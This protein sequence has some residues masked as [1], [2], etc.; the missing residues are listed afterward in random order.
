[1]KLAKRE[2]K[3]IGLLE[4]R[5]EISVSELSGLLG[6]SEST[7]RKQLAVM[8]ENGYLIRTY[9]GVMSVNRVPDETFESK[10]HKN[11]AEK[12]RIAEQARK[13][14]P[15]GSSVALGSGTTVYALSTLLDDLG[16]GVFYSNSMQAADYL[17]HSAGLESHICSGIVRSQ[18]G[19][20]IGSEAVEYFRGLKQVDFAFIGCDAIDAGGDVLSDS[21]SVATA[22]QAILLCARRRYILCDSS[23]IGQ[24]AVA[25]I[26]NLR[27][28]D[29]LITGREES[30]LAERFRTLTEVFCV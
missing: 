9:G 25:R 17:A 3:I 13:L 23:K 28:C 15:K 19:T 10:L 14:V 24:S 4:S 26:T 12:H 16:Q 20:V 8:A 7:L 11:M 6:V 30:G 21:L 5:G 18:T 27:D 2:Q 1:M 29:G 22:E